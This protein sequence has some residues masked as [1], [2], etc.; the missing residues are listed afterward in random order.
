MVNVVGFPLQPEMAVMSKL[1]LAFAQVKRLLV[2]APLRVLNGGP[3]PQDLS[4][5]PRPEDIVATIEVSL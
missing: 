2:T 1:R 4:S 3:V 5:C